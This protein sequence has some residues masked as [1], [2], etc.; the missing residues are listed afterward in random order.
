MWQLKRELTEENKMLYILEHLT[1]FFELLAAI[2]IC[3]V[4]LCEQ[5]GSDFSFALGPTNYVVGST[6][7]RILVPDCNNDDL[8]FLFERD[9]GI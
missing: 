9:F 3:Y 4:L 1:P 5:G 7:E 6:E 2:S 8:A